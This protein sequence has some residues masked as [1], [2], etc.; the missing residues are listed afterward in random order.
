MKTRIIIALDG[1]AACGKST[2]AKALAKKLNYVYI[3]SGAMYRA[4]TLYCL[5]N[6][7]D[8]NNPVAIQEALEH[9][10]ISF[11]VENGM[12]Q[13]L[14]NGQNV[15]ATIRTMR[16]SEAVSPVST[17]SAVRRKLVELQQELGK[18]KGIVMDG[19]DI[20]TVVF[21]NAELKLFVTASIAVRTQRRLLELR[22]KGDHI[23][24]AETI[25]QNLLDRDKIDS[26]REDSPLRQADDAIVIDN[27]QLTQEQQLDLALDLAQI[28]INQQD[29][30][31]AK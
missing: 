13:T 19:R 7:V 4:V 6:Q 3:D 10:D 18:E 16:V 30:I 11:R 12:N 31:L 9:I 2:L 28:C 21:P 27:S 1:F 25:Q 17:I 29:P 15:E 26:S 5:E 14:L 24:A 23:T 22:A 8:W 20:G